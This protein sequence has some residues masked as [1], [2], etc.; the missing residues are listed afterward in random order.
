MFRT[1]KHPEKRKKMMFSRESDFEAALI[2]VLSNKGWE[3]EVFSYP[4]EKE[5]I[6]NWAKILFDNNRI[7]FTG[8]ILIMSL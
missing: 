5:L 2:K 7:I 3:S 6:D 4:T 1:V 8:R